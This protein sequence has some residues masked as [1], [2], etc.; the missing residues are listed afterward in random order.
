[1]PTIVTPSLFQGAYAIAQVEQ[2]NVAAV[3][4]LYINDLEPKFL[5]EL[6]GVALAEAVIPD[7]VTGP[8][9]KLRNGDTFI[10]YNGR[11]QKYEGLKPLIIKHIYFYHLRDQV[12]VTTGSGEKVIAKAST[13]SSLRKQVNA[14]NNMVTGNCILREY[15]QVKI[16]EF[17]SY[18][19]DGVPYCKHLFSTI[20]SIGI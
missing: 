15:L 20:N 13:A 5:S 9:L 16:A 3:V 18:F 11:E 6:L 7:N 19:I 4:Q 8:L 10:G 12:S 14:W 2:P 17:S 1:M